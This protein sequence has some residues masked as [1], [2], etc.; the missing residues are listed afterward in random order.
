VNPRRTSVFLAGLVLATA[1]ATAAPVRAPVQEQIDLQS[2]RE[3]VVPWLAQQPESRVIVSKA[4]GVLGLDTSAGP[5]SLW[6]APTRGGGSCYLIDIHALPVENA[7]AMCTAR[8][9]RSDYAVRPWHTETWV[10]GGYLRLFGA[11]VTPEVASVEVRFA[12][13]TRDTL[14]PAGGFVLRELGVDEEPVVVIARDE[15][16][17]ELRRREMPGPKSFRRDLPFPIGPYRK[18][19]K[20]KTWAGHLMTFAI[21]PGTNASVCERTLYRGAQAWSCGPGPSR[22]GPHAVSV[23]ASTWK[24]VVLLEGSVGRAISRLEVWYADGSASRIPI[25]EQ[26]VLFELPRNRIP[27]IL[28]G[29]DANGGIVSRRPVR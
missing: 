29:V 9:V 3:A 13:G 26:Y 23:H 12:D 28:V 8:P 6:V 15:N 27:R 24:G 4:R 17:S 16:G 7:G 20:L 11:R 19:I 25:V 14:P 18:V 10:A 2:R 21:A 5:V 22:L 1:G